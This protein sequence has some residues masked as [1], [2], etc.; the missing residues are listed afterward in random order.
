MTLESEGGALDRVSTAPA[1]Q[2]RQMQDAPSRRALKA[3]I[4]LPPDKPFEL[5]I[6]YV[7]RE[8]HDPFRTKLSIDTDGSMHASKASRETMYRI[9]RKLSEQGLVNEEQI[10]ILKKL[11]DA[12]VV[13]VLKSLVEIDQETEREKMEAE[14]KY[15]FQH[16]SPSKASW[17]TL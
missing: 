16:G 1:L 8:E 6:H 4:L 9:V 13:Q 5:E 7:N 15:L 3:Q 12:D 2:N 14:I 11:I 17:C 10:T